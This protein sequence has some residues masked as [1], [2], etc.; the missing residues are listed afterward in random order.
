MP[1]IEN[2]S[3]RPLEIATVSC[4]PGRIGISACPG[5]K[6]PRPGFGV[7]YERDARTDIAA[8]ASWGAT[9]LLSLMEHGELKRY[10]VADIGAHAQAARLA[11]HHLPIVDHL[12]PDRHFEAA[13]TTIGP[14]L[15]ERLAAGGSVAIHC[16]A[17]HGRSGTVACRLLVDMGMDPEAAIGHV[18][19]Q[20]PKA[21]STEAQWSY[22][23]TRAW[24]A[25]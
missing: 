4:G 25:P 17:G 2:S 14:T 24:L 9:V 23:T 18:R 7:P 8:I 1:Y 13:W 11:W 3:N 16:L 19:A 15:Q 6:Q 5:K 21:V 22:L 20:R 10:G 12:A